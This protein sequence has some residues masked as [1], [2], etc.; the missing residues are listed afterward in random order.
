MSLCSLVFLHNRLHLFIYSFILT[1]EQKQFWVGNRDGARIFGHSAHDFVNT[2][3]DDQ[4]VAASNALEGKMWMLYVSVIN[5]TQGNTMKLDW[6]TEE[7]IDQ[8][9]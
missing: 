4:A 3:T 1:Q 5:R 8:Q 6:L 7:I 2:L 9:A